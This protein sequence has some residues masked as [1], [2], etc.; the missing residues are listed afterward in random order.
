M[1]RDP[2]ALLAGREPRLLHVYEEGV[3]IAARYMD[4]WPCSRK[5]TARISS[6][7]GR[8]HAPLITRLA[9]RFRGRLALNTLRSCDSRRSTVGGSMPRLALSAKCRLQP[10]PRSSALRLS[11][12]PT[13]PVFPSSGRDGL[14]R[15]ITTTRKAS[16]S[17]TPV[18]YA[19]T[20]CIVYIDGQMVNGVVETQ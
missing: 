19:A 15:S 1:P 3:A 9:R 16:V 18:K 20:R 7:A 8:A 13:C 17:C 10:C 4:S 5:R 2:D 11:A 12:E 6:S 14:G